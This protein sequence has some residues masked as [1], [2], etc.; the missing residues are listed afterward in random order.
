MIKKVSLVILFLSILVTSGCAKAE[1][2]VTVI[3]EP[4]IYES[5]DLVYSVDNNI[6]LE[7]SETDVSYNVEIDIQYCKQVICDGREYTKWCWECPKENG[8]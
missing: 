4:I 2:I 3:D 8:R 7:I 5:D 6:F 1:P